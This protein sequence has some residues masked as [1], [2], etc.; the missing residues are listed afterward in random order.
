MNRNVSAT[1][2]QVSAMQ[3]PSLCT[4][5][6]SSELKQSLLDCLQQEG[7]VVLDAQAVSR[8]DTAGLQLLAA[9]ARDLCEAGRAHA[10]VGVSAEFSRAVSQLGLQSL[11]ALPASD[12]PAVRSPN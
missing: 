10:W 6:E 3:L 11:L 4:L 1:P 5:R 8:V 7:V 2:D 12:P 9:F